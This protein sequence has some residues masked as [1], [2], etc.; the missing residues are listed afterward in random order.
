MRNLI[1]TSTPG[2]SGTGDRLVIESQTP[3]GTRILR[4]V[5]AR[6]YIARSV[7]IMGLVGVALIH[8]LDS[9]SKFKE[10]PYIF[11][12]YVGLMLASLMVAGLLLHVENWRTWAAAGGLAG[13]TIV[14][15]VLSR[16]TGLP[17]APNDI[18]NWGESLGLA[19]LLVEGC[20]VALA[21]Y[22]LFMMRS[23]C[24]S[25]NQIR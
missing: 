22:R 19:S 2:E 6:G 24:L 13:A 4:V 12:M 7:G 20:I 1:R 15:Y 23:G 10:T 17:G 18:G 14:G 11:W 16:T 8:L 5:D 3:Q 9:G 21:I 25:R